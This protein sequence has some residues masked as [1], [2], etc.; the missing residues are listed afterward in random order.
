[1]TAPAVRARGTAVCVAGPAGSGKS[2]LGAAFARLTGALLLDLD[3]ATNP[4]LVEIARLTGAGDDLDH[5]SLRGPV[6]AARY[7]CLAD[8]AR[9]NLRLGA[10]VTLVAPFTAEC[11]DEA[12]WSRLQAQLQAADARLVWVSVSAEVARERRRSRGLR[13]DAKAWFED[14]LP[15][16]DPPTVRGVIVADG[17][18][19]ADDEARRIALGL[20]LIS[21][22]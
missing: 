10:L 14:L 19:A 3:T 22:D 4:L 8:V 2:T 11:A 21:P 20:G 9:E 5:P 17:S 13:R 18:A 7:R 6:R 15:T 12:E 1:M 16:P